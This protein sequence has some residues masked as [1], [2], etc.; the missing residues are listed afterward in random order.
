MT[1]RCPIC[2]SESAFER[3]AASIDLW[4]CP[5]CDHC[6]S[7][8]STIGEPEDYSPEYLE[9]A[10]RNWFENPNIALFETIRQI[11]MHYKP[12][13]S[14]IDVGCGN[15]AFLK[16]IRNKNPE[17][18][19]TGIDLARNQPT[20]GIT[21]IQGDA[22]VSDFDRQYDFV[23]SLAVIE[24][25]IDIQMFIRR[26]RSLCVHGGFVVVM[27][28][29]ERSI[30]YDVARLLHDL[31]YKTPCERLYS[32]HHLNHFN[33][34]SLRRLVEMNN[35]AV[36]KTLLHNIPLAAVDLPVSS[37]LGRV[38]LL[39]GVRGT[40]LLG[41]LTG[42]TYLQTVICQKPDAGKN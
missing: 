5:S 34:S 9:M 28:L 40:F 41:R 27:T 7:D 32:K 10:H 3:R 2:D 25:V 26:L 30:L 31:G 17:L 11:I 36:L 18:S 42:R 12:G 15:G 4:R 19:L 8:V 33:T 23:V 39:M 38:G 24:H 35:L 1:L 14:L 21:F 37:H 20:E 16:Y 6:F 29:N 13:A 22:L